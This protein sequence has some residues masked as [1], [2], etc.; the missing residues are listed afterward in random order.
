MWF[1]SCGSWGFFKAVIIVDQYW[2][3]E[4]V[5]AGGE[6]RAEAPSESE[7]GPGLAPPFFPGHGA[8]AVASGGRQESWLHAGGIWPR[9]CNTVPGSL[10]L[11]F[12][13]SGWGLG[14]AAHAGARGTCPGEPRLEAALSRPRAAPGSGAG[15]QQHESDGVLREDPGGGAL[16]GRQPTGL[17]PH[18]A[19]G[20]PLQEG[21]RQGEFGRAGNHNMALPGE[22]VTERAGGQRSPGAHAFCC[23]PGVSKERLERLEASTVR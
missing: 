18:P 3:A 12:S 19:G 21:H 4:Q 14:L 6:D 7:H 5:V 10:L 15:Q 16:W 1:V 23:C 17:Q 2:N 13:G 20:D 22:W 8:G 11:S 9:C